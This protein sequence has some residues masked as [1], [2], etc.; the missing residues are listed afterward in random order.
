MRCHTKCPECGGIMC[1]N[2]NNG[3]KVKMCRDCWLKENK[4]IKGIWVVY[5]LE[6]NREI[7]NILMKKRYSFI[8][9]PTIDI[10]FKHKSNK[11]ESKMEKKK[12]IE[13]LNKRVKV[14]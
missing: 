9:Y 8:L 6:A 10:L 14:K 13:K 7:Q 4:K 2:G 3:H 11:D 5:D 1:K 12:I